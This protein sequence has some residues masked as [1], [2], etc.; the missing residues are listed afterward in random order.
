MQTHDESDP[1]VA[2]QRAR[3]RSNGATE[4]VS[5]SIADP[6]TAS[7]AAMLE[8]QRLA[9][10]TSVSRLVAPTDQEVAREDEASTASRSP[11]LDVVGKGGGSPL[12][13]DLRSEM[14][15]RLGADFGDVRVHRDATASESAKA[16]DAHA[17]TVGN[18]VVFR[19]DRWAPDS[20]AGKHTLAHELTHVIQQRAGPVAG[21][22]T[23]DGIRL[24]DP[25]DPFERAA[26]RTADVAM[27]APEPVAGPMGSESS[28]PASAQRQGEEEEDEELQGEFVQRQGEEE[29]EEEELQGEFVQ[30]QGEE[31]EE[32]VAQGEFVQRQGEEEEEEEAMA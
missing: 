15:G 11:V 5:R 25:A 2:P 21:S 7:P 22:E 32:E 13:D 16:V 4:S 10:N 18:D 26:D 9:G 8:L 23:G 14:E 24:S 1:L 31:E 17:Y 12:G 30:R 6:G 19:S 29:E 28:A 3:T 20:D 27:S